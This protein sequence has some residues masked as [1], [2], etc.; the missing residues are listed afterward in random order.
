M[1]FVGTLPTEIKHLTLDIL[2]LVP[3]QLSTLKNDLST[4]KSVISDHYKRS[5]IH[6]H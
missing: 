6:D 2:V 1:M 5:I 3:V 4:C